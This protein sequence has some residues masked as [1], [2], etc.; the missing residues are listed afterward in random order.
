MRHLR[1]DDGKQNVEVVHHKIQND[2]HI[3]TTWVEQS[4]TVRLHK[5]RIFDERLCRD[6]SRIEALHMPHLHLHTGFVSQFLQG[7]GLLGRGH[8]GLFDKDMLAFLQSL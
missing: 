2:R 6:K 8:D 4:Q 1:L 3:G 5:Q 7:I